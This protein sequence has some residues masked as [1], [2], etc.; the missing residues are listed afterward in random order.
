MVMTRAGTGS[1]LALEFRS[2][3]ES[4]DMS[5]PLPRS[6]ETKSMLT[7]ELASDRGACGSSR[8]LVGWSVAELAAKDSAPDAEMNADC[9]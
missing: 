7:A 3:N 6:W 9:A 5:G 8:R 1:L 2:G 4:R